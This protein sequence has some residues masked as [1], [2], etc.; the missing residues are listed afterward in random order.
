MKTKKMI[1]MLLDRLAETHEDLARV[2]EE[3]RHTSLD[4]TER[5]LREVSNHAKTRHAFDDY[6][7]EA[8]ATQRSMQALLD[9]KDKLLNEKPDGYVPVAM[10]NSLRDER[11][12]LLDRVACLE[13]KLMPAND[14]YASLHRRS[15]ES[16]EM[17][18]ETVRQALDCD[19]FPKIAFIK[20]LHRTSDVGLKDAKDEV[21]ASTLYKTWQEMRGEA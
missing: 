7:M 4:H 13:K 17:M 5:L 8:E 3:G 14:D 18:L 20:M 9:Q 16:D 21:E 1:E 2:R 19:Y 6:K 12:D 15:E 11:N 10:F